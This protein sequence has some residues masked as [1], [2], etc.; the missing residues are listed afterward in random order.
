VAVFQLLTRFAWIE[1]EAAEQGI[2]VTH[3]AAV[4][5][6]RIQRRQTF[7]RLRD[8]RRFLRQTGQSADDIL[9]RVRLDMLSNA[10]REKVIAP[11]TV[12]DAELDRFLDRNGGNIRVPE[13]RN[14]RVVLTRTRA[15][16]LAAKRELA[17]GGKWSAVARRYS[18][19]EASRSNGGRMPSVAKGMLVRRLDRA[20]FHAPRHR[21]VGPVRTQFG[22][23]V[24]WV[25]RIKPAREH[26][27]GWSRRHVRPIV[28]S[29]AQQR[30]LDRFITDFEERWRSR[31]A[32]APRYAKYEQCAPAG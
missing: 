14:L 27:R 29:R 25:S 13:R 1:G 22:W 23:Y 10:I 21:L 26:S 28:L 17:A 16:A 4:R 5:E 24:V 19:D 7:P 31:T 8:W 32:C 15:A 9:R 12:T 3:Q 20:A 6:L 2:T 18:I 30:A 11:I